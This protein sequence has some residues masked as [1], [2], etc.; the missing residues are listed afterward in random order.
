MSPELPEGVDEQD[1]I[2]PS[3]LPT[4]VSCAARFHM[5][6]LPNGRMKGR[7]VHDSSI[8]DKRHSEVGMIVRVDDR[9]SWNF[10][11]GLHF[12]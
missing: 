4:A 12:C 3:I 11:H 2:V 5:N 9:S 10:F 8:W 1:W 6:I 7:I